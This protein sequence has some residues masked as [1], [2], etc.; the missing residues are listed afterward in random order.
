RAGHRRDP[1]SVH[2]QGAPASELDR[3]RRHRAR[4]VEHRRLRDGG[5]QEDGGRE[6][7]A[8]KRRGAQKDYRVP[9]AFVSSAVNVAPPMSGSVATIFSTVRVSAAILSISSPGL[10]AAD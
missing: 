10:R 1:L 5:G 2:L 4:I 7:S 9:P 3:L 8:P 6:R